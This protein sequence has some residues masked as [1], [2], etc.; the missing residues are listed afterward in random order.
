MQYWMLVVATVTIAGECAGAAAKHGHPATHPLA[1]NVL[2]FQLIKKLYGSAP[3][4]V[5]PLGIEALHSGMQCFDTVFSMGVLY[6]RRSPIDH[7]LELRECLHAD[8]ELVLETLII[9]GGKGEVLVP[10]ARYAKMRNVWFIPSV[11]TL[12]TWLHRC[13]FK[14]GRVVDINQTSDRK[15]AQH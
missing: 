7:L 13:G 12:L 9:E 8:G 14:N 4:Y 3:V 5:L 10:E 1:L 15:A 11:D 6:H 2:Q